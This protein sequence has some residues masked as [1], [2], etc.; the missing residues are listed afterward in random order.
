MF[1]KQ[2]RHVEMIRSDLPNS[3]VR[4]DYRA[5]LWNTGDSSS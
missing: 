4:V 3:A 5:V 2:A 1:Q